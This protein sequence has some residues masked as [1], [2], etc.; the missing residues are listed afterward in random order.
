TNKNLGYLSLSS[1]LGGASTLA[2]E[3]KTL[4]HKNVRIV[5]IDATTEE[6]I[7]QI[8]MAVLKAKIPFFCVDPGVFTAHLAYLRYSS[9][10]K[11]TNK[12]F[13][14]IGSVSELT[15]RQ[16]R[17]LRYERQVYIETLPAETLIDYAFHPETASAL[18]EQLTGKTDQYDVVGIDTVELPEHICCL[19]TLSAKYA[20]DENEVT[21]LI[22]KGLAEITAQVL[23]RESSPVSALYSSGGD[24]VVAITKRLQGNGVILKDEVEPLTVYGNLTGG[25]CREIPIITK[26]GF[27]GDDNTLVHCIDYLSAKVSTQKKE[28]A[29]M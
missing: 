1:V 29:V 17:K 13:V 16:I 18:V 11:R 4:Y 26:G 8:A 3:L 7:H 23:E 24:V 20:I 28:T 15:Q 12:I 9:G 21:C 27:V 2:R 19:K 22:N 10:R 14:A 25:S 5:V 6:D